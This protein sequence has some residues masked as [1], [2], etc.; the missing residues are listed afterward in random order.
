V[1]KAANLAARKGMLVVNAAGNDGDDKWKAI[2]TPADGDSVLTVG[3]IDPDKDFHINFSSFGPSADKRLKPNVSAYGKVVT[4]SPNKITTA[5]GTSFSSPLVAGFAA[6]AWQSNRSLTNMQLFHEI[7]KSGHLYPYFDYAHGFGIP[8]ASYFINPKTQKERT[9]KILETDTAYQI[10][11]VDTSFLS[12]SA[13]P[14]GAD[15]NLTDNFIMKAA[16]SSKTEKNANQQIEKLPFNKILKV[17][18]MGS[19]I[20]ILFYHIEG[21]NGVLKIYYVIKVEQAEVLTLNKKDYE[22]G[23]KVRIFYRGYMQEIDI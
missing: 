9:F 17:A 12:G 19:R 11:I 2:A 23:E 18:T 10:I 7:E 1:V 20:D 3:G 15:S 16:D 13:I 4:S 22:P 21:K 5:Y 6:C 14:E 8:Q